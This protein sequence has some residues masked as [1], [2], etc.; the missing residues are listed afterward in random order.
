MASYIVNAQNQKLLGAFF[1]DA[2]C[3]VPRFR[4]FMPVMKRD[5]VTSPMMNAPELTRK[6]I[7]VAFRREAGDL[8]P[9]PPVFPDHSRFILSTS[10]SNIQLMLSRQG[11][12]AQGGEE[13]PGT[14]GEAV[15]VQ[16]YD[17]AGLGDGRCGGGPGCGGGGNAVPETKR[18]HP[19]GR[20]GGEIALGIHGDRARVGTGQARRRRRVR[21]RPPGGID[22]IRQEERA[23]RRIGGRRKVPMGDHGGRAGGE[24]ERRRFPASSGGGGGRRRGGEVHQ[25]GGSVEPRRAF[26]RHRRRS[27]R[28]RIDA[29]GIR[30]EERARRRVGGRREVSMGYH[31]GRTR[32]EERVRCRDRFCGAAGGSGRGEEG[33]QFGGSGESRRAFARRL[34]ERNAGR[35]QPHSLFLRPSRRMP[36]PISIDQRPFLVADHE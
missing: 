4:L 35:L 13:V 36:Q 8:P 25:L 21:V 17:A 20:R 23:R 24:D 28:T 7:R 31:G 6:Y 16:R 2:C 18:P 9:P 3:H 5:A 30:Y 1:L 22:R 19:L 14:V 33:R 11:G 27:P 10:F 32:D 12:G 34:G 15:I 26:A 29:D